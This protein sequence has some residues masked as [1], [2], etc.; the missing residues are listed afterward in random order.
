MSTS[1]LSKDVHLR[2]LRA[3]AMRNRA[4]LLEAA[5]AAF[6]A[7]GTDASLDDIARQA[8][9]GIGTLYRHFP[10]R[11][12]LVEAL[13]QSGVQELIASGQELLESDDPFEALA[14]WL[15]ALLHNTTTYRGLSAS[16]VGAAGGGSRL[17]TACHEQYAVATSLVV[18][19]KEAGALRSDATPAEVLDLVSAIA[20]VSERGLGSKAERLLALALDGLRSEPD[21]DG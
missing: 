10:T 12:D 17:S 14:T 19:A 20:W 4:R 5:E 8:G 15:Q 13:I 7:K 18:R 16:L 11:D 3:D 1:E 9:V 6:S 21:R 2:Y